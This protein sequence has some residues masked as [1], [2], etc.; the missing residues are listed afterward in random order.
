MEQFSLF[1]EN[2]FSDTTPKTA[3][4]LARR[5]ALL[6]EE[7]RVGEWDYDRLLPSLKDYQKIVAKY[8]GVVSF[9]YRDNKYEAIEA[10]N[11]VRFM[12]TWKQRAEWLTDRIEAMESE[13]RKLL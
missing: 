9:K 8:R 12:R 6:R 10:R 11:V 3:S 4:A 7:L 13:I 2:A 1:E 5:V